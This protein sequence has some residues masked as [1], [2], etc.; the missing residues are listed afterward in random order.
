MNSRLCQIALVATRL[1]RSRT[2]LYRLPRITSKV[3]LRSI[4]STR[5]VKE[6]YLQGYKDNE[7]FHG[8]IQFCQLFVILIINK[9]I[10]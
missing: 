3:G 8:K 10:R 5:V 7:R 6:Q 2:P 1:T 4:S 9:V